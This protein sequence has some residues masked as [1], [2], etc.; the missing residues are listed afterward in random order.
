MTVSEFGQ[1]ESPVILDAPAKLTLSLAVAGRRSDGLHQLRS[2]MVTIDLADELR[3]EPGGKGLRVIWCNRDNAGSGHAEPDPSTRLSLESEDENL[4]SRALRSV[5]RRATI[6]IRKRIPVGGGLGGGSAD[7][8][9]VLR[10]AQC[11]DPA[12]AISL[13]SDVPFCVVGGRA[14]VGGAGEQIE[15]LPFISQSFLLLIPPLKVS[16][17]AV[18]RE[19]DLQ[20][21]RG[22]AAHQ[23]RRNDLM[24]PALSIDPRLGR[25]R[26]IMR[27]FSGQDPNL[28]GSGCAWYVD[29]DRAALG[30]DRRQWLEDGPSRARLVQVRT[31]PAGWKASHSTD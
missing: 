24:G 10:W 14:L 21:Q 20:P 27:E 8:A 22:G 2:E 31:V 30:V 17:A 1:S 29:G 5:G 11:F 25:W 4:A 19:W 26:D 15:P 13:G 18:Y 3:L 28:A 12:I 16:T 23:A 7:A 9:A 6:Q